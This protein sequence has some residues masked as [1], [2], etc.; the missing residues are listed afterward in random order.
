MNLRVCVLPTCVWVYVNV[1]IGVHVGGNIDVKKNFFIPAQ[2][3][4]FVLEYC[5]LVCSSFNAMQTFYVDF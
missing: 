4:E 5:H 2:N 1:F 3:Q